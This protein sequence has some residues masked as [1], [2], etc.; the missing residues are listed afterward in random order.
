MLKIIFKI[1]GSATTQEICFVI[2]LYITVPY[3][4]AINTYNTVHTGPK[5]H[6]GGAQFGFASWLYHS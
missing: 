1:N 2:A 3:D 4:A 5:S 6:D